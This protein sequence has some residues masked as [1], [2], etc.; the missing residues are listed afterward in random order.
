MAPLTFYAN[1]KF[2]SQL[3]AGKVVCAIFWGAQGINL[4]DFSEPG[5]TVNS[6]RY[7]KSL[8]KLKGRIAH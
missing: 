2:R 3:S 7:I 6:K 1:K 4:L 8:I 5:A